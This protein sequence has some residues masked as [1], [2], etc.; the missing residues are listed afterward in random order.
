MSP[1]QQYFNFENRCLYKNLDNS[2]EKWPEM[3]GEIFLN[4]IICPVNI[5]SYLHYEVY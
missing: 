3:K 4:I 5:S 1:W 2:N